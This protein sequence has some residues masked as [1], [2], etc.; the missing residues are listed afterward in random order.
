ME[1]N[2]INKSLGLILDKINPQGSAYPSPFPIAKSWNYL[3]LERD[4]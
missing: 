4:Q 1:P 3:L 2:K